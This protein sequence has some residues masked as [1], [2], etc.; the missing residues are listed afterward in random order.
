[1]DEIEHMEIPDCIEEGCKGFVY[2]EKRMADNTMKRIPAKI[3]CYSSLVKSINFVKNLRDTSEDYHHTQVVRS[4]HDLLHDVHDGEAWT[5]MEAGLKQEIGANG[6]I[7]D[8]EQYHGSRKPLFGIT[9]NRPHSTGALYG[10][11]NN[12]HRSVHYLPR[13]IYL[14]MTIPSPKEPSL[15]QMN[16]L[17]TPLVKDLKCMI[18]RMYEKVLPP[19]VNIMGS[20]QVSD[21]P[22]S[23]KFSG[24]ASHS[25]KQ[26]PCSFCHITHDDINLPAGYDIPNFELRDD[27]EQLKYTFK[28]QQARSI[29]A[30]KKIF[31]DYGSCHSE[32]NYLP[33]WLPISSSP[34]DFMHN[35]YDVIQDGHLLD[36]P[37]WRKFE[38]IINRTIWPSGIECLPDNLAMNHSL[39]KADQWRRLCNIQ[40]FILWLIWRAPNSDNISSTAPDI[41]P[42]SI[43]PTFQCNVK[44]IYHMALLLSVA[45]HILASQSISLFDAHCAQ[46]YLQQYCQESLHLKVHLKPNHHYSM[47]YESVIKRFG[48][49]YVTWL[50]AFE[51]CN[52]ALEKVNVNGHAAGEMELT[53]LCDW[54]LKQHIYELG[55][56]LPEDVSEKEKALLKRVGIETTPACRTLEATVAAFQ[57]GMHIYGLLLDYARSLWPELDIVDDFTVHA[58]ATPFLVDGSV[59]SYPFIIKNGIH[60][61]SDTAIQTQADQYAC[62]DC[63]DGYVLPCRLIYHFEITV[64]LEEPA[65]C[66]V[67]QKCVADNNLPSMPW[68][69]YA[70][71]FRSYLVYADRFSALEV[72]STSKL[73]SSVAVIPI[74]SN[75]LRDIPLWIVLSID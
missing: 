8:V 16:Y 26:H 57:D 56:S 43:P 54:I 45:E 4:E 40:P 69:L 75:V 6:I 24:A 22:A 23:R 13:N 39:Q 38:N 74:T 55:I 66:S 64:G 65:L 44:K 11:F 29:C 19:Q 59:K 34:L 27:F 63:G 42:R 3:H 73:F 14:A 30:Q 61:G 41:P 60:Y 52:G 18:M 48:P 5:Q 72:I 53:L 1:M 36:A 31:N 7:Q 33:G 46:C 67:I 62:V 68:D 49:V 17:L 70:T 25:H 51:H 50:F 21:L 47:H 28:W 35:Y 12:L 15:D 10:C 20:M 9:D 71:N 37:D 58:G 2:H 32:M